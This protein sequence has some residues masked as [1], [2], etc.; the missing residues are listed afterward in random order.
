MPIPVIYYWILRD[1]PDAVYA[2]PGADSTRQY[3]RPMFPDKTDSMCGHIVVIPQDCELNNSP[4]PATCFPVCIGQPPAA[5]MECIL[6]PSGCSCFRVFNTIQKTFDRFQHWQDSMQ[7]AVEQECSFDA[8][9][10]SCDDILEDPLC[11]SD[12]QFRYVSYSRDLA[13]TSGYEERFVGEGNYLPLDYIN[14][15]TAMPDYKELETYR[16]V[17]QYNCVDDVF[18]QN[19][20]HGENFVGRLTLPRSGLEAKDHYYCAVLIA[21]SHYVQ[22]LYAETGSFWSR[23]ST[24]PRISAILH[25]MLQ[26]QTVD[27]DALMRLLEN[28]GYRSGDE[29][30]LIQMRSHFITNESKMTSALTSQLERQWYGSCCMVHEQKLFVFLNVSHYKRSTDKLF[31]QEL[32][33]FLREGLLVAGISRSF[34]DVRSIQAAYLQTEIALET[35]EQVN[36]TYWYFK[37]DDY[38]YWDLLHHGC[39]NFLPHQICH[40]AINALLEY[41]RKNNTELCPTLKA[42]IVHQYNAVSTANTLCVAR[43]TFL[44]RLARIEELTRVDLSQFQTRLYLGLSFALFEQHAVRE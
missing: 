44:K 6:L 16:H 37:Y 28:Q 38:A 11:L 21:L 43:S 41:D 4:M 17:Y 22:R 20:F 27:V 9:I 12:S 15:L 24:L 14:Q 8:L 31:N 29:F 23:S 5:G 30:K 40:P 34:T 32:A 25:T 3:A 35:G 7:Q 36:P 39:R 1:F 18:H 13:Q 42:Y 33:L 2:N 26:G 19:I 10:Q